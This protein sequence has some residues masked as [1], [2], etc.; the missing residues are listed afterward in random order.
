MGFYSQRLLGAFR[1]A[2]FTVDA[3]LDRIGPLGQAGLER[4]STVPADAALDGALDPLAAL[5]RLFVLQQEVPAGAFGAGLDVP[6]LL[7]SGVLRRSGDAVRAVIDIRPYASPD[8]GATGYLASDPVPGMDTTTGAI[9]PDFVLGPSPASLTLT[10]LTNRTPVGSALDLGTGCGVQSLH[11]ARH[12][13]RVVAT[14]LNPRALELARLSAALSGIE[15]DLR[16]GSL[17]EPVAGEGFDLIVSNPPYVMSPPSTDAERLT[18]REGTLAADGLVEQVVRGAAGH[19]NPGGTAQL[20]VNW[21][22]T[23]TQPWEDRVAGWVRGSGL[24]CWV[25]ERERLDRF[26][27][28]E[29]W[30]ADAGLNG[31]P[32]WRPAYDAWLAYFAELGIE[33]VGMGWIHLTNAGRADPVLRFESWPHAV[34]QPVG[35]V[36]AADRAAVDASLLPVAALLA[37]RPRLGEVDQETIGDPGAT[38]PRHIVLRQRTGLLRAIRADT[39]LAAVLGSLDG[40]L[41]LGQTLAAVADILELDAGELAAGMLPS[42]REALR[43]QFL[44]L[45]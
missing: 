44:L 29:L 8:D 19:L 12:C 16:L 39:A 13:A 25:I 17:Y 24:D 34:H 2:D 43:D 31:T 7:A 9:R 21:A 32:R 20:L 14:D 28:I 26:A 6:A 37:T 35:T 38:D 18:Y 41:T 4:N 36:L 40:T 10:Q 15:L 11:L 45:D 5:I 42:V 33:E 1:A 22:V 30:L 27:Y 3:V 23:G